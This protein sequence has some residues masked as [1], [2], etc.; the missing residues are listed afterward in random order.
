MNNSQRRI[1]Y[2]SCE[3]QQTRDLSAWASLFVRL[4]FLIASLSLAC[5]SGLF[6]QSA[7]K[8]RDATTESGMLEPHFDGSS[9]KQYIVEFMG[10]GVAS[11]DFDRDGLL[12]V[13]FLNGAPL[14]PNADK[15]S[16]SNRMYRN[17]GDMHFESVELEA[18]CQEDGYGLGVVAVDYDADGFEDLF[19]SN[20]GQN[21][22]L[23][24]NGD[25]TFQDVTECSGLGAQSLFSAGVCFMDGDGD[26]DNDLF[27]GNYVDFSFKVH[28]AKAPTAYPFPPGPRDYKWLPDSY[29]ENLGDG[30]FEDRSQESG[31]AQVAGPTMGVVAGDFDGDG[32]SDIFAV[33]DG[34]PNHL[35]LNDGTGTFEESGIFSGLA[36]DVKGFANGSMGV[37]AGDVDGDLLTD[38]LVTTYTEQRPVLFRNAGDGFF[39][40][41]TRKSRIGVQVVPHVNWSTA[42][43]DFDC[44]GDRDA[45]IC[46]GHFLKNAKEL[47]SLTD[48]GV[49]NTVM[50]NVGGGEF[51]PVSALPKTAHA[52]SSRGAAFDDFDND[53]DIDVIILNCADRPQVLENLQF[54]SGEKSGV[55]WLA[56][57]LVGADSNR[58]AL[59]AKIELS[60]GEN[61]QLAVRRCGR[62]Y[63]SHFGSRLH[64]GSASA[65]PV[66]LL[67]TWPNGKQQLLESVKW[68]QQLVVQQPKDDF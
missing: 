60:Q 49:A 42:L 15:S 25:G 54:G 3:A 31:I 53:G 5:S 47:T 55:N 30:T 10:A 37:D 43:V 46:N 27:V 23:R 48:Y 39:D 29:F 24:N 35:Y 68:N 33:C 41:H 9:G 59:G 57:K 19:L 2:P 51:E 62:G 7:I 28:E 13:Y 21:R 1:A 61:R 6:A 12:D 38:L 66:K 20:F 36:Y 44:D 58:D 16:I 11:L 45:F 4:F 26:G 50:Q 52:K 22:L 64:F 32:T 67:I 40:D 56:I 18:F 34:A 63:Q 14:G 8:F 65:T 17:L